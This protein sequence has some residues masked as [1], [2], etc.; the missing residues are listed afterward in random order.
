MDGEK[1]LES[2]ACAL[3]LKILIQGRL[4]VT[5][6]RL[7]F[8]SYFNDKTLFGKETKIQILFSDVSRVE[9]KTNAMVFDNSISVFTK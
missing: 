2:Y 1:V 9:K 3:S 4:Y 8:H 7:L 6:K 5:T